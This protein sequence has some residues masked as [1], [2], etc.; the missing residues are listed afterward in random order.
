MFEQGRD[1]AAGHFTNTAD[2]P[3]FEEFY[4]DCPNCRKVEK[5]LFF[6][7]TYPRYPRS[8][9]EKNI[10]VIRQYFA[11]KATPTNESAKELIHEAV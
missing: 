8:E 7:P 4:R 11:A 3:R 6:L 1:I 2:S 9:V 5:E 10:E